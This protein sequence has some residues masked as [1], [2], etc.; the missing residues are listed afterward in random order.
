[1]SKTPIATVSIVAPR[2]S[3]FL[4]ILLTILVVLGLVG[5]AGYW[6]YKKWEHER[7]DRIVAELQLAGQLEVLKGVQGRLAHQGL[8]ADS[9]KHVVAAAKRLNGKLVAALRITVAQ[10]DTAIS[11]ATL[12]T[13]TD[14][15]GTRTAH[16]RDSTAMGVLDATLT[17]PPAP[18][19]L[20]IQY[21]FTQPAFS[22]EIGFVQVGD[23][24]VAV[25]YWQGTKVQVRAPYFKKPP[26][27]LRPLGGF[28]EMNVFTKG[29]VEARAGGVLRIQQ[30]RVQA[31]LSTDQ[32]L[33]FGGRYEF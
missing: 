10:R 13:K 25:V 24:M 28:A 7:D 1:M 32:A 33:G 9:L 6:G 19:P 3:S 21:T 12:P 2:T 8:V 29:L 5:G 26:K 17:A 16:F 27:A 11:H 18:K 14:P 4:A 31:F 23:S 22:P 30:W 20:G 15:T